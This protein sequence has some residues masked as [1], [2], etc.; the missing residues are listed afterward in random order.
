MKQE[1]NAASGKV[2][3]EATCVHYWIID[4]PEGPSSKGVCQ[5]CGAT[6]EFKNYVVGRSWLDQK[7][8][9]S[10][11]FASGRELRNNIQRLP[12]Y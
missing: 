9:H 6:S 8:T 2:K 10:K 3:V 5:Y 7:I 1:R 4:S 12:K 11:R